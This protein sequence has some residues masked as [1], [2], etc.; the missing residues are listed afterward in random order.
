MM[1]SS[2]KRE[3][4]NVQGFENLCFPFRRPD[5]VG[6]G[7]A[8][9]YISHTNGSDLDHIPRM[10]T[11]TSQFPTGDAQRYIPEVPLWVHF[12]LERNHWYH[13]TQHIPDAGLIVV[14]Y[15]RGLQSSARTTP[16]IAI[17]IPCLYRFG[18]ALVQPR[19]GGI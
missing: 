10:P 4:F 6:V 7:W 1:V 16:D 5:T 9:V 11:L 2:S 13:R 3:L 14:S 15:S 19:P 12:K 18:Q 8:E 17:H